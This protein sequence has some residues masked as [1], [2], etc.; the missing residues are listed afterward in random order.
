[1][2]NREEAVNHLKVAEAVQRWMKEYQRYLLDGD[3][4]ILHPKAK[5]ALIC[6]ITDLIND[7][8]P[9]A[10]APKRRRSG[11]EGKISAVGE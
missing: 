3:P 5:A 10:E 9:D 7:V 2:A 6:M 11:T 4:N 8:L 1:M